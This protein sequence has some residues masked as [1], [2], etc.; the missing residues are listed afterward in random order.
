MQRLLYFV[1][2]LFV[3]RQDH[4]PWGV[5]SGAVTVTVTVTSLLTSTCRAGHFRGLRVVA[6]GPDPAYCHPTLGTPV[7]MTFML[8]LPLATPRG[9]HD[10]A[11]KDCRDRGSLLAVRA[12]CQVTAPEPGHHH[13]RPKSW[14]GTDL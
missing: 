2:Q 9:P 3:K 1:L 5:R 13:L 4:F 11:C 10:H 7:P 14:R 6:Q 8:L 12:R